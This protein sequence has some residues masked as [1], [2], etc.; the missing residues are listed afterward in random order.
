MDQQTKQD[1]EDKLKIIEENEI[2]QKEIEKL[3]Q[4]LVFR[5]ELYSHCLIIQLGV[6]IH[7]V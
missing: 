3:K 4:D 1:A 7:I 5:D 2:L 6:R